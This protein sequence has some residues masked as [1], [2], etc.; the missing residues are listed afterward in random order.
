M[1]KRAVALLL[2]ALFLFHTS[3]N[4]ISTNRPT[5]LPAAGKKV[6]ERKAFDFSEMTDEELRSIIDQATNE[7][8]D[9][10]KNDGGYKTSDEGWI[11][12]DEGDIKITV[13]GN[14]EIKEWFGTPYLDVKAII[15]NGSQSE[16]Q[17]CIDNASINGWQI[18]DDGIWDEPVKPGLKNRASYGLNLNDAGVNSIHEI[19][20]IKFLFIVKSY[21]DGKTLYE[22]G[23]TSWSLD[24]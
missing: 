12:L 16:I 23:T 22:T 13:A 15:E 7:L 9:R 17:V 8:N 14:F 1:K 20:E 3:A 19:D 5:P 18:S 10:S 2:M 24:Q 21:P 4:A 6:K 11:V